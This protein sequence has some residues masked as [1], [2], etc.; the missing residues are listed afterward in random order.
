M[1]VVIGAQVAEVCLAPRLTLVSFV[2]M[3]CCGLAHTVG[4]TLRIAVRVCSPRFRSPNDDTQTRIP[5]PSLL[6]LG[7]SEGRSLED[8]SLALPFVMIAARIIDLRFARGV[9]VSQVSFEYDGSESLDSLNLSSNLGSDP[10]VLSLSESSC[11]NIPSDSKLC[12]IFLLLIHQTA[13][14]IRV[15]GL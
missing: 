3:L 8:S 13:H 5:K 9:A 1:I 12:R 14:V 7:C 6:S 10:I 4:T 15:F 2:P 11:P